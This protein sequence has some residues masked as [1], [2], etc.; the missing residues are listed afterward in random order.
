[1]GGTVAV[2]ILETGLEIDAV[3]TNTAALP[4]SVIFWNN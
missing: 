2:L 3:V 4:I 1:L